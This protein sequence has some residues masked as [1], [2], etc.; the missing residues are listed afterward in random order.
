[1]EQSPVS[2]APLFTTWN[3]FSST[4]C[5]AGFR[6]SCMGSSPGGKG[7]L[8]SMNNS[9]LISFSTGG[10]FGSLGG[11]TGMGLLMFIL[12]LPLIL[13]AATVMAPVSNST[14]PSIELTSSACVVSTSVF[15][16]SAIDTG[17][18]RST[19]FSPAT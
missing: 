6:L 17:V 11:N 9:V 10:S 15:A 19:K 18:Y 4:P 1:M 14:L 8:G 2:S 13:F 16:G 7:W 5:R 3:F 12:I